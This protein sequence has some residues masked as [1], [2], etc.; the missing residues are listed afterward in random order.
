MPTK[1]KRAEIVEIAKLHYQD[2]EYRHRNFWEIVFKSVLAIISMIGLPFFLIKETFMINILY[3]FPIL[4]CILCLFTMFLL[5]SEAIRMQAVRNKYK[6]LLETL[7]PDY[8]EIP[9]GELSKFSLLKIK[10]TAQ[11]QFLYYSLIIVSIFQMVLIF[12]GR[13]A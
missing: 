6:I 3:I 2:Y 10:I 12:T 8:K 5:K 4:S 9:I 1:E 7:S 13:F 11:I